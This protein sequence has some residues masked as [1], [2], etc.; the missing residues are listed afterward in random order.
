MGFYVFPF[1]KIY[2][3]S[4]KWVMIHSLENHILNCS[5]LK[6][7]N[8]CVIIIWNYSFQGNYLVF[9]KFESLDRNT[10]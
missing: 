3:S 9:L 7:L 8:P 10:F 5:L 4:W 2:L 1:Y 6:T